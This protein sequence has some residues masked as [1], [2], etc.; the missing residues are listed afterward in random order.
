[1]LVGTNPD[2]G[3]RAGRYLMPENGA[4]IAALEA[5]SGARATVV[6]KPSK[7]LVDVS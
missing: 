1:M 6:G 4:Q 7:L 3:N 2:T 5:A